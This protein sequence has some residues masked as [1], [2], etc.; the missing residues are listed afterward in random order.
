[1]G[2]PLSLFFFFFVFL[3]FLGPLLFS[4]G[5]NVEYETHCFSKVLALNTLIAMKKIVKEESKTKGEE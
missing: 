2:I 3:P 4:D 1:M 5:S